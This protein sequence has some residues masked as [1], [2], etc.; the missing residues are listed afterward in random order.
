[1]LDMPGDDAPHPQAIGEEI[2][3]LAPNI[4]VL[5]PWKGPAYLQASIDRVT[6][7]LARHTPH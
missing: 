3:R 4:E 2:A 7:F 6:A 5:H 1:M